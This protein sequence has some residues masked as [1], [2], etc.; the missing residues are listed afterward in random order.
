MRVK[1]SPCRTQYIHSSSPSNI[2]H[3][4]AADLDIRFVSE[5][6]VELQVLPLTTMP[7]HIQRTTMPAH[8]QR[9]TMPALIQRTTMPAHIQ[10]TTM[11]AHIAIESELAGDRCDHQ[12]GQDVHDDGHRHLGYHGQGEEVSQGEEVRRWVGKPGKGAASPAA[13]AKGG[14]TGAEFHDYNDDYDDDD[15]DAYLMST[16][17]LV[18]HPPALAIGVHLSSLAGLPAGPM[19]RLQPLSPVGCLYHSCNMRIH[20]MCITAEF[21][22]A[23]TFVFAL[24]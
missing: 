5:A 16:Y 19:N 9:T 15:D 6:C 1:F 11:P 4:F 2:L 23:L 3:H 14:G 7:A 13:A 24:H 20:G 10:R 21:L 22:F 12:R 17:N 8:I 18:V